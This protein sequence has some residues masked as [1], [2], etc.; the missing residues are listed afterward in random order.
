MCIYNTDFW[1]RTDSNT[2]ICMCLYI[3]FPG[4]PLITSFY[5]EEVTLAK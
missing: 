5:A 2:F 4:P 1:S 3:Y